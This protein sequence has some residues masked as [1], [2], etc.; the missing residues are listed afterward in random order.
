M[1][2]EWSAGCEN[3]CIFE[4]AQNTEFSLEL[5]ISCKTQNFRIMIARS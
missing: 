2:S 5:K 4:H 1:S 3:E